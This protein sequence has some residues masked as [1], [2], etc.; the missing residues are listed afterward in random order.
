MTVTDDVTEALADIEYRHDPE[1]SWPDWLLAYAQE[2]IP[3]LLGVVRA[4]LEVITTPATGKVYRPFVGGERYFS[5]RTI[6]DAIATA[7]A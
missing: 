6:R 2:D 5:E 4:V 7:L 1:N 3:L